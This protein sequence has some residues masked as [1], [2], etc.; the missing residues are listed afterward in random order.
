MRVL[1]FSVLEGC[2]VRNK[3]APH[4]GCRALS[5]RHQQRCRLD[6]QESRQAGAVFVAGL[7][8]RTYSVD[9]RMGCVADRETGGLLAGGGCDLGTVSLPGGEPVAPALRCSA[10]DRRGVEWGG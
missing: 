6:C 10:P 5:L 2:H 1:L 3:S 4:S 8:G 9:R 7:Q